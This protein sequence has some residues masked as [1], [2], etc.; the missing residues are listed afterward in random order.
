MFAYAR[1]RQHS[2]LEH[3]YA[4]RRRAMRLRAVPAFVDSH[5]RY[6]PP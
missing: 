3:I 5:Q 4:M 2:C 1:M 6:L